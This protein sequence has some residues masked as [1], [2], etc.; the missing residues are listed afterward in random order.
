[1]QKNKSSK[2]PPQKPSLEKV[3]SRLANIILFVAGV[4]C[5]TV[6]CL[7]LIK[8][9]LGVAGTGLGTGLILLFAAT[10]D[11]FESLKGGGIEVT[12]KKLEATIIE[13]DNTVQELKQL[14]QLSGH[15][16][17][18]LLS[19]TN[20]NG[21]KVSFENGY[22]LIEQ[23]RE[24]L[25]NLNC[26]EQ[27]IGK[28]IQP[29]RDTTLVMLVT[30]VMGPVM[31]RLWDTRIS[32]VTDIQNLRAQNLDNEKISIAENRLEV[33]VSFLDTTKHANRYPIEKMTA[34][35]IPFVAQAPELTRDEKDSYINYL[36]P[37]IT[38]IDF[39]VANSYIKTPELW[40]PILTIQQ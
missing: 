34:A 28:T 36:K 40:R 39:T 32:L 3:I 25:K 35:M 37:W 15:T 31:T 33:L 9:N 1:M 12:T 17:A 13:A 23:L 10:I 22:N 19:D 11:R 2:S 8:E 30:R 7:M 24:I 5:I 38:E 26:D 6:G 21:E 4:I 20:R 18:L 27:T 14:A 29:W 16:L